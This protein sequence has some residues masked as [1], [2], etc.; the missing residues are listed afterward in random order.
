MHA[1]SSD[2]LDAFPALDR[3]GDDGL[4]LDELA[5]FLKGDKEA[6]SLLDS[7][8]NGILTRKELWTTINGLQQ[9][10]EEYGGVDQGWEGDKQEPE[11]MAVD[12]TLDNGDSAD[13]QD[14]FKWQDYV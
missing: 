10:D 9:L 1:S 7:D 3:N 6:F 2:L 12:D 11:E 14:S 4:S 8:Q 13:K 5:D